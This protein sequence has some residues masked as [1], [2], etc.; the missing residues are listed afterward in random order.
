MPIL[1]VL[2]LAEIR[3][4][5]AQISPSVNYTKPQINAALQAVEDWF[6]NARPVLNGSINAA[7]L[8]F[9]LTPEQK[10]QLVKFWL[11]QKFGRE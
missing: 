2:Q 8:P 9:I 5:C 4:K 10:R 6:E 1:S 3:Q 11:L 7:T